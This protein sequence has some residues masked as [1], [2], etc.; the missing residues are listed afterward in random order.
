[1]SSVRNGTQCDFW[2]FTEGVTC[3][4]ERSHPRKQ[5]GNR[6]VVGPS[7][8]N[9][10]ARGVAFLGLA[11][12][13]FARCVG[14]SVERLR[15]FPETLVTENELLKTKNGWR[16]LKIVFLKNYSSRPSEGRIEVR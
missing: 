12:L 10:R 11:I 3:K 15:N 2:H 5:H 7:A 16:N 6:S 9:G 4:D 1:M 8:A 13:P 14:V